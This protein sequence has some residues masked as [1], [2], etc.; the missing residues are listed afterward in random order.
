MRSPT[1]F[2]SILLVR[3]LSLTISNSVLNLFVAHKSF[4]GIVRPD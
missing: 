4:W 1:L 2:R 3:L